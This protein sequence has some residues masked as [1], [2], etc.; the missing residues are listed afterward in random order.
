MEMGGA[1]RISK[2]EE[3]AGGKGV[4]VALA[5][6]EFGQKTNLLGNWAGHS[7]KWIVETCRA[8]G[9]ESTGPEL[10]GANRKCYTFLSDDPTLNHTELLE[11][12]P[13]MT[14][15]KLE[16]FIHVFEEQMKQSDLAVLS[17]SWPKHASEGAYT[18]LV[19]KAAALNKKVILDCA[20]AMLENA[21]E[22]GFFGLHLNEHEAK[23]MCGT[24]D[25][26]EAIQQLSEK[27]DLIALT[28]GKE[29]LY[30]NYLG[31]LIHANVTI[32][33][34]VSTVGSGDCLTAGVAYG[35]SNGL[36]VEEIA[37]HGVAF[38]AANCLRKDLGMLYRSDV[39]ALL[40][41]V[42]IKELSYA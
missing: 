33:K 24:D 9:I 3:F 29:G 12:G 10:E 20:G 26:M 35:V 31:K 32:D 39:E 25:P 41:K 28:R 13:E 37:R 16:E 7:G 1:N 4:H 40:P 5:L 38:G 22:K 27:V 30:L 18:A 2:Q 34:V 15:E 21:L 42:T 8:L 36:S 6:S 11:P 14:R 17:G 23:A 19:E